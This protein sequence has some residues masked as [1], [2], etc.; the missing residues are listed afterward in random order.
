[1]TS[2]AGSPPAPLFILQN[3]KPVTALLFSTSNS[4]LFYTGNREGDFTVYTLALRRILFSA[5]SHKQ[6]ILS[7]VELDEA[8]VLTHAR[9]GSIFKWSKTSHNSYE[10]ECKYFLL[11]K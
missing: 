8:T 11:P 3:S 6:A 9:N 10:Y 1:M 4:D 7:I 2:T 5:N